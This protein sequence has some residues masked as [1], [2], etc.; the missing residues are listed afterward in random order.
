MMI[1]KRLA[2]SNL[3]MLIVP[4][5]LIVVIAV[6]VLEGFTEIY[7]KKIKV[8]EEDSGISFI[9]KTLFMYNKEIRNNYDKIND[10]NKT[11]EDLKNAGY[12]FIITSDGDTIFSNITDTDK[13]A[14]SKLE[15]D[16]LTSSDSIVLE[17][18]SISLVKNSLTKDGKN[19]NMLA[20]KSN[21]NLMSRQQMKAEART[22]LLSYMGVVFIVALLIIMLTNGILSSRVSKS[23]IKP[24][25]LLS[26]G[27]G[28]IE[29]GNLDF[30]LSY[31][32]TDEFAKVCR[33]FDKMRVRL[34][35]SIDMQL[36]YEQN[37]K[38]LVAGISHDLRT[39]LTTIKGYSKGLKDG[40]ANTDEKRERYYEIIYSKT[41]DMDNLVDKL[42][43]FSKLDTGKFPFNFENI[44]C[45]EFF[46]DFFSNA[47]PEFRGKGLD[48]TYKNNCKDNIFIRM[49]FEEIRRVLTNILE[50]SVKYKVQEYGKVD[51]TIEEMEGSVV[52]KIKDDGP[53][54]LEENLS[55]LFASFYRE[56]QSRAN[57]S[58]GS[59]LGLSICEYIIKAHNGTITAEN[60]NGLAIII[61]LPINKKI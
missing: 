24:L 15:R 49:D 12:D 8:F 58:E 51:I 40:I 42:F 3:F 57:S 54:V 10:Y 14:M 23:L 48:L 11:K 59:G 26:Y 1:K 21:N 22:F 41:C 46:L 4:A 35:E 50:N 19:I 52:L 18:N 37:R 39:P 17:V 9:Q 28:Q 38:E 43:F 16:V 34:K 55:K 32:G 29:E 53:G 5:I 33:D 30:K 27:A 61:T 47:I 7:G 2:M 6:G 36:K 31:K 20:V 25:E 45:N 56:D 13:N 60:D 44:N